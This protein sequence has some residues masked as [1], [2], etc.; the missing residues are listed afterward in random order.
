TKPAHSTA[1]S[2]RKAQAPPDTN[3]I[4]TPSD[5]TTQPEEPPSRPCPNPP[6]S[7]CSASACS[8]SPPCA[9][10]AAESNAPQYAG[11]RAGSFLQEGLNPPAPPFLSRTGR[12]FSTCWIRCGPHEF[13]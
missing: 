10:A 9:A 5:S 4:T 13:G 1:W 2:S 11:F 6:P 12:V 7:A 3:P 8:A